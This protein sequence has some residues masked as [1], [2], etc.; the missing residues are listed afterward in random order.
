MNH[1]PQKRSNKTDKKDA[2]KL[3]GIT[4]SPV[5]ESRINPRPNYKEIKVKNGSISIV[6]HIKKYLEENFESTN[7]LGIYIGKAVDPT[8]RWGKHK[9]ESEKKENVKYKLMLVIEVFTE[10]DVGEWYKPFANNEKFCLFYEQT[11][12]ILLN[13]ER[14]PNVSVMNNVM[15][16]TVREGKLSKTTPESTSLYILIGELKDETKESWREL[17]HHPPANLNPDNELPLSEDEIVHSTS[18]M[19]LKGDQLAVGSKNAQE[20]HSNVTEDRTM[21]P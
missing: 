2:Q 4:T 12:V 6:A 15:N 8:G 9:K 14:I 18:R 13:A 1:I 7:N 16:K 17:H 19:S 21:S 5:F 10:D 20:E 11:L 3:D